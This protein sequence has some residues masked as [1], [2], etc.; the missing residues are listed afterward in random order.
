MGSCLSQTQSHIQKPMTMNTE[1]YQNILQKFSDMAVKDCLIWMGTGGMDTLDQC[2]SGTVYSL[3]VRGPLALV[4]DSIVR[5]TDGILQKTC[6]CDLTASEWECGMQHIIHWLEDVYRK[7]KEANDDQRQ[8]TII[9][10]FVNIIELKEE[11]AFSEN[12]DNIRVIII[13]ELGKI[14]DNPHNSEITAV[15]A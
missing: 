1:E 11:K 5:I 8:E 10:T 12:L 2:P 6:D 7:A 15:E 9:R 3:M 14:R 13:R 4:C